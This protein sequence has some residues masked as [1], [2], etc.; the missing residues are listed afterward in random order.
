MDWTK[1]YSAEWRVF[2]VNRRTWADAES[3]NNIDS[4]S[5][6][7][8]A[9]GSLI[10]SATVKVTGELPSDYYRV[11]MLA[12][13]GGDVARVNVATMLFD[14]KDDESNYGTRLTSLDGFSVLHPADVAAVT[15]GEYAP[16][17]IDGAKY[18]GD[19]LASAI[20]APVEID[21]S[22]T[23]NENIV[24]EVGS[25]VL[26]CAWDILNSGNFVIQID[27]FGTVHVR[28]M[29]SEASLII[30]STKSDILQ[31]EVKHVSDMSD[32]PNRYVV[33]DG[34]IV[35]VAVNDDPE[36]TVSTVSRG[37]NV[38]LIDTSPKLINGE[39]YGEYAR[40]MLKKSSVLREEQAYTR[41]YA[42]NVYP[43]SLVKSSLNSLSGDIRVKSQSIKC[44]KGITVSEKAYKEINLWE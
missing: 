17:G 39:T 36:S 26:E 25:S 12:N 33:I 34:N 41:E 27:G 13:Q 29:P 11:V 23:L 3:V 38:D 20:N 21:G 30:D 18:A 4:I 14:V 28:P 9:D 32:I 35:S 22:F 40:R 8:T 31:N 37:Y 2:R 6:T 10:E 43:Y 24:H 5:I 16:A 19:L 44:G 7:R 1:S 15:I 42:P